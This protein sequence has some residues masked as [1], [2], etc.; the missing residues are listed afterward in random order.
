MKLDA[1]D[2]RILN[3]IQADNRVTAEALSQALPLSPSA[4]TRRLQRLRTEG[5]IAMDA[6]ILSEELTAGRLSALIQVQLDRHTPEGFQRL[7]RELMG[8]AE[9]QWC[10]EVS[11]AFDLALLVTA[12]S[13]GEL[14]ELVDTVFSQNPVVR[15]A[16]TS[17]VKRRWKATLAVPLDARD[18]VE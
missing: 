18:A 2:I 16:E 3:A 5:A 14:N 6:A 11:G 7:R 13:V 8:R 1:L 15:R 17:L 10:A 9:V 12:R 4:I